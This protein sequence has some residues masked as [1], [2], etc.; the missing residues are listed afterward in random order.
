MA[1]LGFKSPVTKSASNQICNALAAIKHWSP[2]QLDNKNIVLNGF[3][4]NEVYM[5]QPPGFVAR[6][7]PF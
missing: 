4:E 1:A 3:V 7:E 6:E 5:N 2:N